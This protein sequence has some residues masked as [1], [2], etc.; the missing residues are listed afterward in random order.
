MKISVEQALVKTATVEIRTLTIAGKQ[1]TLAVFRQLQTEHLIDERSLQMN[2][3]V[4]GRVNYH[5]TR[6]CIQNGEH[7]HLVWQSGAELRRD[8]V[9]KAT[10]EKMIGDYRD[11]IN[12][13]SLALLGIMAASGTW[14]QRD[15]SYVPSEF[16]WQ[17][18]GDR[19][20][21]Y[22][23]ENS[24]IRKLL[25]RNYTDAHPGKEYGDESW[26]KANKER[27]QLE[28]NQWIA[29]IRQRW[30]QSHEEALTEY[31]KRVSERDAYNRD[32]AALYDKLT[33][34]QQLFIAV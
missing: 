19:H 21:T 9:Y 26:L 28:K 20:T 30:P 5:P 17:A 34:A 6:S 15:S 25:Q 7:I 2:G 3:P 29:Q 33:Q 23:N 24:I 13:A 14:F 31:R 22:F 27:E 18:G 32:W 4:W 11:A 8:C 1:L 16:I 12:A 10:P